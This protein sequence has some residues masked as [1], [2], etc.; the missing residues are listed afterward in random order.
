MP[1]HAKAGDFSGFGIVRNKQH[2]NTALQFDIG[3]AVK[4]KKLRNKALGDDP[5]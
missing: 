1:I 2:T 3:V 5:L 4:M